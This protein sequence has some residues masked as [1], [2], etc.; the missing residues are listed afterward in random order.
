MKTVLIDA[1]TYMLTFAEESVIA[2]HNLWASMR[3]NLINRMIRYRNTS[4]NSIHILFDSRCMGG[5]PLA[6]PGVEGVGLHMVGGGIVAAARELLA[7]TGS[8]ERIVVTDDKALAESLREVA[9]VLQP[10]EFQQ[11]EEQAEDAARESEEK[12]HRLAGRILS[13][14]RGARRDAL[15]Q[16]VALGYPAAAK[17]AYLALLEDPEPDLRLHGIAG[18]KLTMPEVFEEQ[19]LRLLRDENEEVLLS[20][21]NHLIGSTRRDIRFSLLRTARECPF[22]EV[23]IRIVGELDLGNDRALARYMVRWYL[24][25]EVAERLFLEPLIDSIEPAV[26]LETAVE[27][28]TSGEHLPTRIRDLLISVI[29]NKVDATHLLCNLTILP[30]PAWETIGQRVATMS[31]DDLEEALARMVE[32]GEPDHRVVG[33]LITMVERAPVRRF[34][35]DWRLMLDQQRRLDLAAAMVRHGEIDDV[36]FLVNAF[37]RFDADTAAGLVRH[38]HDHPISGPAVEAAL[39]VIVSWPPQLVAR[40]T[41]VV[42]R[43]L[44]AHGDALGIKS[45][46]DVFNLLDGDALDHVFQRLTEKIDDLPLSALLAEYSLSPFGMRL[47]ELAG[48][49]KGETQRS[50]LLERLAD[51]KTAHA[52]ATQLVKWGEAELDRAVR[53]RAVGLS[54]AERERWL[55]LLVAMRDDAHLAGLMRGAVSFQAVVRM[56]EGAGQAAA[57]IASALTMAY[58]D[59]G[60]EARSLVLKELNKRVDDLDDA[61][62]ARIHTWSQ[63][64]MTTD[65]RSQLNRLFIHRPVGMSIE[66]KLSVIHDRNISWHDKEEL[67]DALLKD[68]ASFD[69][70][71]GEIVP[72][73][74]GRFRSWLLEGLPE[75]VGQELL[76]AIMR[77]RNKMPGILKERLTEYLYEA[78][79]SILLAVLERRLKDPEADVHF[80]AEFW[81]ERLGGVH[82]DDPQRV[83]KLV[84]ACI[85]RIRDKDSQL[86]V[87]CSL[88]LLDENFEFNRFNLLL[89]DIHRQDTPVPL[90]LKAVDRL[91]FSS[92]VMQADRR[93]LLEVLH[94]LFSHVRRLLAAAGDRRWMAQVMDAIAVLLR[95]MAQSGTDYEA[96]AGARVQIAATAQELV[97]LIRGCPL[98][99]ERFIPTLTVAYE[100]FGTL[101]PAMDTR[102]RGLRLMLARAYI[103]A[104]RPDKARATI[105]S[106][107]EGDLG[108]FA[109]D[110]VQLLLLNGD[111]AGAVGYYKEHLLTGSGDPAEVAAELQRRIALEEGEG[112]GVS[113][114]MATL[115]AIEQGDFQT[116]LEEIETLPSSIAVRDLARWLSL[117]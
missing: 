15:E 105:G 20:V 40:I 24:N 30:E 54:A 108:E 82:L 70:L 107:S 59:L 89:E 104:A 103:Q 97:D 91:R 27:L 100:Q 80:W 25:E 36:V 29:L 4:G 57:T 11:M 106:L 16:L 96:G 62:W 71:F 41:E 21:V 67:R 114:I 31:D 63:V 60:D 92:Y 88:V 53:E 117:S 1:Y 22:E 23:S 48:R 39:S 66:D 13:D 85:D 78:P 109:V 56:A 28:L 44:I 102:L 76:E 90:F 50:F 79:E 26:L 61:A 9:E 18:V 93:Q 6:D 47:I 17:Q 69:T 113:R 2:E 64:D 98:P 87:E 83:R 68:P 94:L 49:G 86:A 95:A 99:L 51:E 115:F 55:P 14:S 32:K 58:L 3:S 111:L 116:A 77:H 52:A 35:S 74:K 38:L 84:G 81:C 43:W 75:R 110:W 45:F 19:L 5:D 65:A 73:V 12:I 42:V 72:K 7:L 33:F 101:L 10:I 46:V 8:R 37:P 112:H 34:L